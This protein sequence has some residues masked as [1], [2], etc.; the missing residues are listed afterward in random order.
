MVAVHT[1]PK[2]V[3]IYPRLHRWV[4]LP[5]LLLLIRGLGDV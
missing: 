1:F 3:V 5:V 2:A 4:S